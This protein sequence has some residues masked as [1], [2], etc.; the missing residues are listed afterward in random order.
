MYN[1]TGGRTVA[2]SSRQERPA[3][4]GDPT[5][6]MRP[7]RTGNSPSRRRS[8]LCASAHQAQALPFHFDVSCW[9][10]IRQFRSH[11][12]LCHSLPPLCLDFRRLYAHMRHTAASRVIETSAE[13]IAVT[14]T[15]LHAP[16]EDLSVL[17]QHFLKRYLQT[18]TS[19]ARTTSCA[20]RLRRS[21]PNRLHRLPVLQPSHKL[22]V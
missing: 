20:H 15:K 6:A 17:L 4:P 7:P 16:G 18:G 9:T 14:L 13:V 12:S 22:L 11:S 10:A 19:I 1:V 5:H 8:M 3:L 21:S 2:Q